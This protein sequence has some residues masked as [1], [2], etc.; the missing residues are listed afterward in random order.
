ML[1]IFG[2]I[3]YFPSIDANLGL[4]DE[5][6]AQHERSHADQIMRDEQRSW[7]AAKDARFNL[8]AT[9]LHKT[10]HFWAKVTF[11][12]EDVGKTPAIGVI[13]IAHFGDHGR[14]EAQ[15]EYEVAGSSIR[16][17]CSHGEARAPGESREFELF[18]VFERPVG[19]PEYSAFFVSG[20]IGVNYTGSG[21]EGRAVTIC[22]YHVGSDNSTSRSINV[23][24]VRGGQ[25]IGGTLH[26]IATVGDMT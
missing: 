14:K 13:S 11:T 26:L 3:G 19:E 21:T 2:L 4:E 5:S 18:S 9:Y 17:A 25:I 15:Q 12:L 7:V 24:S 10:I 22:D 6:R 16:T 8:V 1:L 23:A 20:F